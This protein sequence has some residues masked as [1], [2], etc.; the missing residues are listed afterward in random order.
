MS[1]I[2]Q[3]IVLSKL[4]DIPFNNAL[5][6]SILKR[7]AYQLSDELKINVEVM[8]PFGFEVLNNKNL[9]SKNLRKFYAYL[10]IKAI[11]KEI[12][13]F[14]MIS[15]LYG[16]MLLSNLKK[17]H[18]SF[19]NSIIIKVYQENFIHL[20]SADYISSDKDKLI[21]IQ[22]R[23]VGD[24]IYQDYAN[25][26][27]CC[28][29]AIHKDQD[30]PAM[31]S[32]NVRHRVRTM[33]L[34]IMVENIF[35]H[36]I[37]EMSTDEKTLYHCVFS[38]IDNSLGIFKD[39]ALLQVQANALDIEIMLRLI[40]PRVSEIVTRLKQGNDL[41]LIESDSYHVPGKL[42]I[43]LSRKHYQLAVSFITRTYIEFE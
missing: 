3:V 17:N 28:V 5:W 37:D 30:E 21:D 14:E 26:I 43:E 8:S 13:N 16:E 36:L 31:F 6:R 33:Q 24:S 4:E 12:G 41:I 40:K 2:R 38:K 7:T 15:S 32:T 20:R 42:S 29:S 1:S 35:G 11:P 22:T 18:S 39:N 23:L 34:Y 25:Y 9:L 27:I 10:G 19:Y